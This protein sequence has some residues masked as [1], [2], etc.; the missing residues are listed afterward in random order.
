MNTFTN[1]DGHTVCRLECITDLAF[2]PDEVMERNGGIE[3]FWGGILQLKMMLVAFRM[4]QG[5]EATEMIERAF[6]THI[7]LTDDGISGAFTKVGK[8]AG[9]EM[10]FS[11][12]GGQ[13][14]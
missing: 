1:D 4:E 11:Q 14:T 10:V 12:E 6:P 3:M 5:D 13:C 9:I 7:D 8:D 2:V